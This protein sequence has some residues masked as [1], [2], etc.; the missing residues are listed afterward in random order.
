MKT[1][2]LST[3]LVVL[4]LC[5]GCKNSITTIPELNTIEDISQAKETIKKST[6]EIKAATTDI[7]KETQ[8]IKN[9]A[10]RT[11]AKVTL[12]DRKKIEPHLDKINKS[13][14]IIEENIQN[15]NTTVAELF[16]AT[17]LLNNAGAK[18]NNIEDALTKM[19]KERND[20]INAK[21]KA[22]KDRDSALH[23]ALRWLILASIVGAGA[24]GV[25][26]F[27]YSSKSCLTL[28]AVCIVVMSVAI[29]VET[30]FI[31]LVIGGGV[32]LAALIGLIIYNIVIQKKAFREV[33]NTV[34]IAQDNMTIGSREELFGGRGETGIMD[35]IQSK[36]TMALIKKEKNKMSNLWSY[37][38]RKNGHNKGHNKEFLT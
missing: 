7:I 3:I 38:K 26:G 5:I 14:V 12:S 22:E 28:S 31:Y 34:E 15:I 1:C 8:S 18:I 23:E 25:F 4:L 17:S 30:C 2:L 19:E 37:A 35:S 32:I 29:F 13:S 27:M 20:A 11:K 33:I 10:G 21:I 24:L 9:E 36:N 6:T 16:G